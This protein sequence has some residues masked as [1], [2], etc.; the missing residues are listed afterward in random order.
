MKKTVVGLGEVLW[1]LFPDGARFGGAPANVACH[2]RQLGAKAVMVSAVGDDELG[3]KALAALRDMNV[4][5]D[6]VAKLPQPTGSVK[7]ELDAH[8]KASY[9]FAADTAWDNLPWTPTLQGIAANADAVC[10]GTLGQRSP[11][12]RQTIRRFLAETP[13]P[14]LRIYD[15]N[16]RPP[17][18]SDQLVTESL[19]IAN[20]VKLNDDE[21]PLAASWCDL[22]GDEVAVMKQLLERFDLKLV[23]LTRG[24]HGATLVTKD[25]VCT[26]DG[27]Q[28][29][30][31]D[32]VGAGDSFTA[33][34]A[35]GILRDD[36]LDHVLDHACRL[37]A[38]VCTQP[39]A[40][41]KLPDDLIG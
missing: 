19:Q 25:R 10:F 18:Y 30:V 2:A 20:T 41:P 6:A 8:G 31:A 9:E 17:F 39:G 24:S 3:D 35:V 38:Y 15:V 4:S 37:A 21:L 36:D 27:V 29:E 33:A 40:T 22:T 13:S 5:T 7:V 26:N 11:V 28:V 16:L 12:A 14:A 32:T 34:L 1:D 23:A